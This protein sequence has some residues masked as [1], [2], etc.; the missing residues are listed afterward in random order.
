MLAS[1]DIDKVKEA[2]ELNFGSVDNVRHASAMTLN[3][4]TKVYC[5]KVTPRDLTEAFEGLD[6]P[7]RIQ[8]SCA[9]LERNASTSAFNDS[10]IASLLLDAVTTTASKLGLKG[11]AQEL[12]VFEV[13]ALQKG[14]DWGICAF[15]D[16]RELLG[17]PGENHL[18]PLLGCY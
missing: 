1:P 2:L 16:Y 7:D 6:E 11:T 12:K 17:L 5:R 14:R 8:R 3:V 18:W 4:E 10:D 13:D 15:N 9:G